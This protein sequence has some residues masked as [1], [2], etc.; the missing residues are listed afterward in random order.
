VSDP[1]RKQNHQDH[2]RHRQGDEAEKADERGPALEDRHQAE[3]ETR[4]EEEKEP[5]E[6]LED[7]ERGKNDEEAM[8]IGVEGDDQGAP[9]HAEE[10]IDD[11]TCLALAAHPE[12]ELRPGPWPQ[13][14]GKADDGKVKERENLNGVLGGHFGRGVCVFDR[15]KLVMCRK[16]MRCQ[17]KG[18]ALG[19][20]R[21]D[22]G[23]TPICP[24]MPAVGPNE[25]SGPSAMAKDAGR[26]HPNRQ[27]TLQISWVLRVG[28]A[29]EFIGHGALGINRVAAWSSYFAV[30]GISK[31]NALHLMPLVGTFDVTMALIVLFYPLRGLLLYMTAWALWT[32]LLRPLA[33]ESAWEA[34]ERAGNYGALLAL[35]LLAKGGG[36]K[37]WLRFD[38]V[39]GWDERLQSVVGWT[40]RLTTVLLLLG[41]GALNLLVRK[42]I[43]STQY[44]MLGLHGSSVEPIVG[45]FECALA[46]AVL[47]RHG[48]GLL[49]FVLAWKFATEAL[50]PMAG[51]PIWVFVEHGGSYAAPLALAL[52]VRT[53]DDPVPEPA[54]RSP[55]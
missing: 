48:F 36:W 4:E 14:E 40:L 23:R 42:P 10:P 2:G 25:I 32:A 47:F 15:P 18:K 37:S 52:L 16:P 46:A 3:A 41:H 38:L 54:R 30:V 26:M 29:M 31:V 35:F 49:V 45:A 44:A 7:S 8:P 34:V 27:E 19:T 21:P 11:G 39:D 9:E 1:G 24:E 50:S 55:A 5:F 53:W 13:D 43:F 6:H 33:G 22:E 51:S 17:P 12:E 28:V 20:R